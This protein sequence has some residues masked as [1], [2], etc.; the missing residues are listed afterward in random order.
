M[1]DKYLKLAK[2]LLFMGQMVQRR[3]GE[4]ETEVAA[5]KLVISVGDCQDV[6]SPV[7]QHIVQFGITQREAILAHNTAAFDYRPSA[8]IIYRGK[9]VSA[10]IFERLPQLIATGIEKFNAEE[11]ELLWKKLKSVISIASQLYK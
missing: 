7:L 8:P 4:L 10:E 5:L 11:M 6:F 1:T 2:T 9:N 3:L